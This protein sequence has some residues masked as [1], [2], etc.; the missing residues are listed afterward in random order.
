[1]KY[2]ISE[3]TADL[4]KDLF[5]QL[6]NEADH[7]VSHPSAEGQFFDT[8]SG[9]ACSRE[10]IAGIRDDMRAALGELDRQRGAV[11]INT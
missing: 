10:D 11:I 7:L 1:M 4:M 8:T 2:V 3:K 6:I 5:E 9:G